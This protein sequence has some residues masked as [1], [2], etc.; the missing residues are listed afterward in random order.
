MIAFWT[1]GR[2]VI[3][4]WD[5]LVPPSLVL[6]PSHLFWPADNHRVPYES[7]F[8]SIISPPRRKKGVGEG[9]L[10]ILVHYPSKDCPSTT[11]VRFRIVTKCPY[12]FKPIFRGNCVKLN[13]YHFR[14]ASSQVN[15]TF[16]NA[17]SLAQ[18]N[19]KH[20]RLPT[21]SITQGLCE[22]AL[23]KRK[24]NHDN[25]WK[26]NSKK[27]LPLHPSATTMDPQYLDAMHPLSPSTPTTRITQSNVIHSNGHG[28]CYE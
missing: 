6:S 13:R 27:I 2:D 12:T 25:G 21:S 3:P 4:F 8:V 22:F 18:A 7:R 26:R 16:I 15:S 1:Y 11:I 5:T 10:N 23:F 19:T 9:L 20:H 28:W 17:P 24:P 14:R